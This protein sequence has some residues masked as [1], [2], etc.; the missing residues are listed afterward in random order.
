MLDGFNGPDALPRAVIV[1][2][3][4][5]MVTDPQDRMY[6]YVFQLDKDLFNKLITNLMKNKKTG[7]DG[8]RR[9][10]PDSNVMTHT[11]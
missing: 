5:N 2:G 1:L 8:W 6:R 7:I 4:W 10:Y 11:N 3:D 9:A